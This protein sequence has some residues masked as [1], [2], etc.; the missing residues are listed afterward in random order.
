MT[1]RRSDLDIQTRDIT[2]ENDWA[3]V[4]A[5]TDEESVRQSANVAHIS[6]SNQQR[7][8]KQ[9]AD[10]KAPQQTGQWYDNLGKSNKRRF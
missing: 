4:F 1:E 2:E 3:Y 8:R 5:T 9:A 7:E 10:R 6:R